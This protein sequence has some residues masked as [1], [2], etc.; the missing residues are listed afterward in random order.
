M[1]TL[2]FLLFLTN[3]VLYDVKAD[4]SLTV[5]QAVQMAV[6]NQPAVKQAEQQVEAR[7]ANVEVEK[8]HYYPDISI[9]GLYSRLGPVETIT[10][11]PGETFDLFPANNYDAHLQLRQT[12]YDFGERSASVR[13]AEAEKT[14]VGDRIDLVKS[15]LAY[16]TVAVFNTILIL[17]RSIAV[18]EDQIKALNE[19]LDVTRKKV[20]A[21]T[22]TDFEVLTTQ[23]RIAEARDQ[24]IDA[25]T[26]LD[27]Q[28]IVFRRLTG[29]S[30]QQPVMLRG[31]FEKSTIALM[32]DSLRQVATEQR[33]ELIAARDAVTAAESRVR[34]TS[35]GFRPSLDVTFTSG[36]KNGYI[37][38][39]NRLKGNYT[40]GL[41]LKIPIFNG[42][43]T[44]H[45]TS[46]A[47]ADVRAAQERVAD[48]ER[49][50]NADVSRAIAA[51]NS[52]V[53]KIG[54]SEIQVRQAERAVDLAQS[55]YDA[56]VVTN[57]DV[58]DAQ[59]ALAQARLVHLKA[60]YKYTMSLSQLDQATGKRFW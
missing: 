27:E 35:L 54:N 26:S 22:A 32:P 18:I 21:G 16:Q 58:L 19:H 50:V 33:P 10:V 1:T 46:V 47:D 51:V 45:K 39:L 3:I 43:R 36:F 48:I 55:Q 30:P 17:H 42:F 12:V 60:L 24:L 41:E 38:N 7:R 20:E 4:D 5:Q 6:S 56:G 44:R 2:I 8:S 31:T 25:K 59:T 57:L 11:G 40:A 29:M 34:L 15:N 53:D 28:E 23:V 14:A 13:A 49:Q 37:P 9:R 52:S